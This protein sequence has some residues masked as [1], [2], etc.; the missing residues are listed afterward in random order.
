MHECIHWLVWSGLDNWSGKQPTSVCLFASWFY[1]RSFAVH[2]LPHYLIHSRLVCLFVSVW[3]VCVQEL[4]CDICRFFSFYVRR[5]SCSF[6][7]SHSDRINALN[8]SR[9]MT[10]VHSVKFLTWK[11]FADCILLAVACVRVSAYPTCLQDASESC[12]FL[13]SFKTEKRK[14]K[15]FIVITV[16]IR[17]FGPL[18]MGTSYITNIQSAI[19][20]SFLGRISE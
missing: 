2:S 10:F 17:S 7:K 16:C 6:N 18:K 8:A 12:E 5:I 14:I 19:V 13:W 4:I 9:Q 3:C 15:K 1:F 20:Y 11:N